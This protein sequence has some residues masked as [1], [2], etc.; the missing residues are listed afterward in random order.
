M[1]NDFSYYANLSANGLSISDDETKAFIYLHLQGPH[2]PLNMDENIQYVEESTLIQ[3]TKGSFRIVFEYLRMLKELGLYDDSVIV[4][5]GDH[6]NYL[7]NELTRPARTGLMVKPA[8]SAGE[9]IGMSHAPVSPDQLH[10][11]LME[12]LFGS[13]EGFGDTFF[14]VNEGDDVI[15]EYVINRWRYEIRGDGRDFDNW[16][17][18]G[19]FS[20]EFWP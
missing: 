8:G 9:P 4:I 11:T 16:T 2:P 18:I 1:I 12:G 7:G 10:A 15:R 13:S 20:E 6:G 14:D 17:F 3:Q 5:M 19:L